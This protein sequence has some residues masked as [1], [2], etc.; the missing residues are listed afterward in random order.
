MGQILMLIG[1]KNPE[2]LATII[3]SGITKNT[4]SG[5]PY[6]FIPDEQVTEN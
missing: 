2:T 4:E 3:N 6:L 5:M 1:D